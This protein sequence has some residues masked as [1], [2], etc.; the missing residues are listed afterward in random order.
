MPHLLAFAS[1]TVGSFDGIVYSTSNVNFDTRPALQLF[2]TALCAANQ[3]LNRKIIQMILCLG[4]HFK[5]YVMRSVKT[6]RMLQNAKL[7][8]W[9][10]FKA[11]S[12]LFPECLSFVSMTFT[13][14]VKIK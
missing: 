3:L 5:S 7:S 14:K 1:Q 12:E 6:H 10:H 2:V 11:K 8:F 13:S 9:S 4:L